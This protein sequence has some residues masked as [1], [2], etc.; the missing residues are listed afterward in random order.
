MATIK[1]STQHAARLAEG[2]KA[3]MVKPQSAAPARPGHTGKDQRAAPW[4]LYARGGENARRGE[5]VRCGELAGFA[6]GGQLKSKPRGAR[7]AKPG[8]TSQR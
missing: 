1:R 5:T 2:G 7:P 4:P 8:A 6:R 3:H